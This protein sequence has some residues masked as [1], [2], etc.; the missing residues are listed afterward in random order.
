MLSLTSD[1]MP[2]FTYASPEEMRG[3]QEKALN[4][5]VGA[6]S[7]L[8][9]PFWLASAVGVG[10]WSLGQGFRRFE[11]A[12]RATPESLTVWA[13]GG[14]ATDVAGTVQTMVDDGVIT[15]MQTAG[16]AL[17]DMGKAVTPSPKAV[18][19]QMKAAGDGITAKTVDAAHAATRTV[20]K[21]TNR[22]VEQ[23]EVQAD[24]AADVADDTGS[25]LPQGAAAAAAADTAVSPSDSDR[26]SL[27]KPHKKG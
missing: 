13:S 1:D 12:L 22:A 8:W 11:E 4:L 17:Q 9:A 27:R 19:D 18:A 14:G 5:W 10:L 16:K 3:A 26:P 21:A 6:T 20:D 2:N 23:A 7:P 15:P 24:A 25:L